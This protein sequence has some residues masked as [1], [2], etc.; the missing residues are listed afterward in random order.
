MRVFKL[1]VH[2]SASPRD[3]TS[4]ADITRWHR[5]RG[6]SGIG[7][8]KVILGSG[9]IQAGRSESIMGAHALG[10]NQ[11]SLGVCLTGNFE[12]ETPSAGQITSL[13][14]VLK[15]W[16]RQHS[17]GVNAIYG[18]YNVP[19][20]RT[21]TACPGK[22]LKS[23]FEDIKQRVQS[24][25][26]RYKIETKVKDSSVKAALHR[27]LAD[28]GRLSFDEVKGLIT[29]TM[30]GGGTDAQEIADLQAILVNSRS[31]DSRSRQLVDQFVRFTP[32]TTPTPAPSRP[33]GNQLT[34]NFKL[35]EFA[36]NDG[37]PVPDSLRS[38]VQ[39][40]A[41]NLQVLR[42][43]VGQPIHINSGYRTPNYNR[44]VGGVSNSQH[45]LA[46]AGDI[47]VGSMKPSD[48]RSRI[49]SLIGE[50]K[51]KQGGV[52]LYRTFVH[53]DIRGTKARWSKV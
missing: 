18:H 9:Q 11:N 44:A 40:L 52:G 1:V 48:V 46:K 4:V 7:Y 47:R 33:T 5:E 38:N 13:V 3:T 27:A 22:N 6:F 30:D 24:S 50:G 15:D 37:T 36:C 49:L 8:H 17:L 39:E 43:A 20:G 23:L 51:M 16:C 28:D 53:Y 45:L 35:G 21:A 34:A 41:E 14:T 29:A 31:M 2:H 32:R 12:N 19:G 25:T 26:P 10:A 42:D